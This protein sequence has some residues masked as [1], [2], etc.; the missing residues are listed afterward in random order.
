MLIRYIMLFE[1]NPVTIILQL[2]IVV[3]ACLIIMLIYFERSAT[4]GIKQAVDN[5]DIPPCPACPTPPK[6]PDLTS[7]GCPDLVCPTP[8]GCPKCPKCPKCPDVKTSCPKHKGVTVDEIVK[9]I[10][11]GRNQGITTHG[12]YFPL[13]GLGEASVEPAYSPV[14]NMMPNYVGG[15]GVP[16]AISFADQKLL[17]DKGGVALAAKKEPPLMTSQGVFS[18]KDDTPKPATSTP[19]PAEIKDTKP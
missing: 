3:L 9:A 2:L 14:V 18:A 4:T 15:D 16:A 17:G 12:N 19:Q 7:E 1:E 6:C 11:P 5:I 8:E 10:F 13:D